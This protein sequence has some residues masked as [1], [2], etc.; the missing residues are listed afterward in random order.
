MEEGYYALSGHEGF[1]TMLL[2]SPTSRW[3]ASGSVDRTIRLWDLTNPYGTPIVLKGSSDEISSLAFS[4][5]EQFLLSSTYASDAR[6]WHLDVDDLKRLT[7]GLARRNLSENEWAQYVGVNIPYQ[8]TCADLPDLPEPTPL[9]EEETPILTP[10]PVPQTAPVEQGPVCSTGSD[11]AVN[12]TFVN[13]SDQT[14]DVYWIDYNCEQQ[15]YGTLEPGGSYLQGT[16]ATHPWVFVDAKTEETL[17]TF[18][19]GSTDEVVTIP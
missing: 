2:F 5:E 18:V 10:T 13:N 8:S 3:L 12:L 17:K 16:Y 6:L 19:A 15:L 4:P 14:V 7:C 11:V 1:V 9:P